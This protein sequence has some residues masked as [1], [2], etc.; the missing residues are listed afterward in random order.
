MMTTGG[1]WITHQS[2]AVFALI[3]H[4]GSDRVPGLTG[5]YIHYAVGWCSGR[6]AIILL[7]GSWANWRIGYTCA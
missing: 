4:F 5:V 7:C 2:V 1:N 3:C 6:T